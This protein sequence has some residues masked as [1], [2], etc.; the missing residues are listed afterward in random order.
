MGCWSVSLTEDL[1]LVGSLGEFILNLLYDSSG[2]EEERLR[3][4]AGDKVSRGTELWT[5]KASISAS[6]AAALVNTNNCSS[7]S[8][9]P[10]SDERDSN[11]MS[12]IWR[13]CS[14]FSKTFSFRDLASTPST[15]RGFASI[16][17]TFGAISSLTSSGSIRVNKLA[18]LAKSVLTSGLIWGW[19]TK[20]LSW[21]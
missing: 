3:G 21:L 19:G 10:L 4:A 17:L 1:S 16:P 18:D 8:S 7:L 15:S 12:L 6:S 14:S 5:F 13:W 11:S 9:S 2:D 20:S